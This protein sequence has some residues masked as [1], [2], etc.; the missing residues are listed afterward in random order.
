MKII[1]VLAY[2]ASIGGV[3]RYVYGMAKYLASQN[4][5]VILVSLYAD[6]NLFKEEKDIT[7]VDLADKNTLPQSIRFWLNLAKLQKKFAGIVSRE[8]PDVILFN[9]FPATMWARKFRDIPTLCYNYDIHLLYT[10]T[11]INGLPRITRWMW[12][13]IRILI[14]I[15]DKRKWN[16]FN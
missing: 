1:L 3:T 15:Y 11:Y 10:N 7:I 8:K 5:Q 2:M 12:R 14:R 4:D 16:C 13:L 9:D 6:R